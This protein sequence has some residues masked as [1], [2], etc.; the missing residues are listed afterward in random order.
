MGIAQGAKGATT[1]HF[2]TTAAIEIRSATQAI[3]AILTEGVF[4]KERNRGNFWC[5]GLRNVSCGG[6]L[7]RLCYVMVFSSLNLE[8]GL[9]KRKFP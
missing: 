2:N 1:A 3:F 6:N 4:G 8:K 5:F 7:S 9:K